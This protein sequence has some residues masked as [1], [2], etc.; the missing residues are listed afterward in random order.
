MRPSSAPA[1]CERIELIRTRTAQTHC[2][3]TAHTQNFPRSIRFRNRGWSGKKRPTTAGNATQNRLANRADG[4]QH[5]RICPLRP[6]EFP[7]HLATGPRPGT[8][9]RGAILTD[10]ILRPRN[11]GKRGKVEQALKGGRVSPRGIRPQHLQLERGGRRRL[12]IVRRDTAGGDPYDF[13]QRRATAGRAL[14]EHL[15]DFRRRLPLVF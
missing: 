2:I 5:G 11:L 7:S 9:P 15:L 10:H 13:V 4:N 6:R 12:G 3:Y 8:L 1:A 14:L